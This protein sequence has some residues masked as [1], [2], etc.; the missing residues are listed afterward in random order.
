MNVITMYQVLSSSIYCGLHQENHMSP[1]G[2]FWSFQMGT[3]APKARKGFPCL[4]AKLK[5]SEGLLEGPTPFES[6]AR[7]L[8]FILL[9]AHSILLPQLQGTFKILYHYSI[10]T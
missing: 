8:K 3:E 2:P 10:Y 5:P 7:S 9:W 6:F 1:F 4:K